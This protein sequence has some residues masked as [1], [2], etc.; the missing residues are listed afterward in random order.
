M[1]FPSAFCLLFVE[2]FPLVD[3]FSV[4]C[5]HFCMLYVLIFK[6][7]VRYFEDELKSLFNAQCYWFNESRSVRGALF[8]RSEVFGT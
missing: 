7:V 8:L 1:P 4:F 5:T 2:F 6:A 3:G